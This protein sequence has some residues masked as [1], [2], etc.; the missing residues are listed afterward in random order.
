VLP[1]APAG[2]FPVAPTGP[3]YYT[4]LD[5]IRGEKAEKPH[6]WP[7]PR[8]GPIPHSFHE[9]DFSYLDAIPHEQR[10]WAEK[11]HRIPL[12]EHFLFSTGGEFRTRYNSE[13][14][15]RLLGKNDTYQLFRGRAY[16]DVWY[17]D[18]VRVFGE[19]YYGDTCSWTCG[20]A[21]WTATRRSYGSGGKN[22]CTARSG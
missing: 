16:A 9:I 20:C 8:G 17:E 15:T 7:Y 2:S 1:V 18:C 19:F 10:D 13:T 21:N 11:L 5:Q 6:R 22:C 3:G 4:L 12:G 14:N